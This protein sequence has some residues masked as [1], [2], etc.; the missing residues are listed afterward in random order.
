[1]K[2]LKAMT[3]RLQAIAEDQATRLWRLARKAKK[4]GV[5]PKTVHAIR[6][7]GWKMRE[8]LTYPERLIGIVAHSWTPNLE[9]KYAFKAA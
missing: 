2:E 4:H 7:E 5:N 1:M 3:E 9:F 6:E 8:Y